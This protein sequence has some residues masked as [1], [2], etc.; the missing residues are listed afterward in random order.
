[1]KKLYRDAP[2]RNAAGRLGRATVLDKYDEPRYVEKQ[3]AAINRLLKS[4]SI[5]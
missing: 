3:V 4:R 2:L 5:A 1:M